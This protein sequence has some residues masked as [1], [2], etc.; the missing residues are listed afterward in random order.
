MSDNPKRDAALAALD[1][2]RDGMIVGLGTGSTA[3]YFIEALG[4]RVTD[5]LRVRAIATSEAS[6]RL[7][8]EVGVPMASLDDY[9]EIHVTV[10]GA[11]E[12]SPRLDLIKGLGGALLREKVVAKAS[13]RL[14]IV[15]DESKLV[16]QLGERTVV[17][18]EVVPFALPTVGRILREIGGDVHVRTRDGQATVTDNGNWI[19]DWRSGPIAEASELEQTL[20]AITGVVES[21]I[22]AGLA[23]LAIVASSQGVR[24]I[25]KS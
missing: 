15:A 5:G 23:D 18:V 7:A 13:Q 9:P 10:D 22:F 3:N 17:P 8:V 25:V 12:I 1:E 4:R 2:V 11:D 19:V 20:K 21:G 24:R 16:H 6:Y 14:V